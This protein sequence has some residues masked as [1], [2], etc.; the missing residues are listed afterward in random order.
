MP[1]ERRRRSGLRWTVNGAN[2]LVGQFRCILS[3][4][5]EDYWECRTEAD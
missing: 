3:G 5:H 1:S 2:S 4:Y